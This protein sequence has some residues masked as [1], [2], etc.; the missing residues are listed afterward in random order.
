MQKFTFVG[1]VNAVEHNEWGADIE[2][3]ADKNPNDPSIKFNQEVMFV[4]SRKKLPA[5]PRDIDKDCHVSVEYIPTVLKGVSKKSGQPFRISRNMVSEIKILG[6]PKVN[7]TSDVDA[8]STDD[9][10]F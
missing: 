2:V 6:Y 7:Q 1:W 4:V 5:I 10:P 9:A 3:R 8:V